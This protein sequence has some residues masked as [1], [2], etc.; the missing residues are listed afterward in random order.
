MT[1]VVVVL[2]EEM[3]AIQAVN[4]ITAMTKEEEVIATIMIDHHR[5]A[6]IINLLVNEGE[7]ETTTDFI[8]IEAE[9]DTVVAA[10]IDGVVKK[11]RTV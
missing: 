8:M 1:I 10:V 11:R 4:N 7:M 5:V 9:E 2:I 3:T 6:P